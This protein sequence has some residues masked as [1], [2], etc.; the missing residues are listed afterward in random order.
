MIFFLL[1]TINYNILYDDISNQ[2]KNLTTFL[3]GVILY[4]I[5]WT[6]LYRKKDNN[7]LI[8]D[9]LKYG[10]VY[11]FIADCFCMAII[12]KNYY[13]GSITHEITDLNV[14]PK[15]SV[16]KMET[17]IIENAIDSS[18]NK[19]EEESLKVKSDIGKD[20]KKVKAKS[21]IKNINHTPPS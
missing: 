3:L 4:T 11:I 19:K 7:N 9:S 12:Y 8:F 16:Q 10:F 5:V 1:H 6:F 17:D 21:D 2:T 14:S 13:G 20:K 15:V 18:L